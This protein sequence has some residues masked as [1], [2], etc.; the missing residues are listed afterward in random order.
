[1]KHSSLVAF[2]E[3]PA[4]NLFGKTYVPDVSPVAYA[5]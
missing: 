1:M 4:S 5:L 2:L 3:R